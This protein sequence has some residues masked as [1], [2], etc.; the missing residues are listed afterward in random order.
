MLSAN[1]LRLGAFLVLV[2]CTHQATDD[3]LDDA[4]ATLHQQIA[5]IKAALT[6]SLQRS[7]SIA[8]RTF[9]VIN[10]DRDRVLQQIRHAYAVTDVRGDIGSVSRAAIVLTRQFGE[11]KARRAQKGVGD[12]NVE[13]DRTS[14]RILAYVSGT[15]SELVVLNAL[16]RIKL[17]LVQA[18]VDITIL[19]R[20]LINNTVRVSQL[21]AVRARRINREARQASCS[22]VDYQQLLNAVVAQG[23]KAVLHNFLVRDQ[24]IQGVFNTFAQN[25]LLEIE[26]R[27]AIANYLAD[28]QDFDEEEEDYE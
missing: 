9:A 13:T 6:Q 3:G 2:I 23:Q 17:L 20:Q 24:Q 21:V 19:T 14:Q 5:T 28:T 22:S 16:R 27:T 1:A 25:A 12:V 11:R 18:D 4:R 8:A 7:N 10:A 26:P 15:A